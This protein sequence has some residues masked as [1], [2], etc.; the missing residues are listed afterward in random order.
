M[1]KILRLDEVPKPGEPLIPKIDAG[2]RAVMEEE[3]TERAKRI[4]ARLSNRQIKQLRARRNELYAQLNGKMR[5]SFVMRVIWAILGIIIRPRKV[6]YNDLIKERWEL[7]QEYQQI[8]HKLKSRRNANLIQRRTKIRKRGNELNILIARLAPLAKEFAAIGQR[9][10]AHEAVIAW[11]K[12]DA[13]NREAFLREART[14]EEQIKAAFRQLP[15]LH[16]IGTDSRGNYFCDIPIIERIIFKE[17]KVLYKI[18]TTRQG[19]IQRLLG[20]WDSALP[21]GVNFPDLYSEETLENLSAVC[22]R[23]VSAERSKVGKGLF[24]AISRLDS[25]DGIPAKVLYG[26][27]LDWY[28]TQDHTKT[29]WA[30]GVTNDRKVHWFTLE[31]NPHILIAGSTKSGKSNHVNQMIA[32]FVSLNTPAELRVLLIDLKGGVEFVHWNGIKHAL[33]PMVKSADTV[34]EALQWLRSIMETRLAQF[35]QIRAKNLASYNEKSPEKLPRLLCIVDEL[36]TLIGLGDLTTAIHNELR[37]LSS[38]GRAVGVHLILCT[39]HSSSDVLPGWIK[40]NMSLRIS[41][42][43]PSHTASMVILDS[44]TAAALPNIPGRLVFSVGRFEVI[45]QSPYI[46]D[47]E[48]A[49]AVTLSQQ[50]AEPESDI[51]TVATPELTAPKFGREHCIAIAIAQLDGKL[52]PSRIHEI[53]GNHAMP[54]RGIA[55]L[56]TAIVETAGGIG[57]A[58]WHDGQEFVIGKDRKTYTL[59]R[60]AQP[61][62][63]ADTSEFE[64][65]DVPLETEETTI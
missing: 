26:R 36:A 13:E 16:H 20:R 21:Y 23:V 54:R 57:G 29:P 31:D 45:A 19:I 58:V 28:P 27:I 11:E 22:D 7:W 56:V 41:G 53:V 3:I 46:S 44:V 62:A 30:A 18:K 15:K 32:T 55:N 52:S 51:A 17:D 5:R 61:E 63:D 12:E 47:D 43:M 6:R 24:Y 59:N 25:P 49:R 42:K 2:N 8:Q 1:N 65:I 34:L 50:Y 38:Q 35:E 48:V 14:W 39:Q 64:T 4:K 60:V 10:A 37:V 9:L 33:R 40:T